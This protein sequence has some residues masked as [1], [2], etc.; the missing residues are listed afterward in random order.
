ML[1]AGTTLDER[2][3]LE[4]LL[5]RGGQASVWRARDRVSGE[6]RALKILS[7]HGAHPT[8]L[9]RARREARSLVAV[10]HPSVVRCYGL[11][12]DP[13]RELLAL[14][15]EYVVGTTLSAALERGQLSA[16]AREHAALHLARALAHRHARGIVHRDLKPSNVMLGEGFTEAPEAGEHIKLLDFGIATA[17]GNPEPMTRL[18]VEVGTRLFMAPE[19]LMPSWFPEGSGDLPASDV[20]S[21]GVVAHQLLTGRHPLRS[22]W[23]ERDEEL[24]LAYRHRAPVELTSSSAE[25]RAVLERALTFTPEQRP[26][27]AAELL[28]TLEPSHGVTTLAALPLA[29]ATRAHAGLLRAE[30]VT[31][32]TLPGA[33]EGYPG[34]PSLTQPSARAPALLGPPYSSLPPSPH[35]EIPPAPPRSGARPRS[36]ALALGLGLAALVASLVVVLVGW[37]GWAAWRAAAQ[38][39]D[40]LELPSSAPNPSLTLEL[41]PPEP[42]PAPSPWRHYVCDC[43]GPVKPES[44]RDLPRDLPPGERW[45]F[46]PSWV[47]RADEPTKNVLTQ[48]PDATLCAATRAGATRCWRLA[49]ERDRAPLRVTTEDVTTQSLTITVLSASAPGA[50][51]LGRTTLPVD[52][53]RTS[54]LL[55]GRKFGGFGDAAVKYGAFWLDP[56]GDSLAA[57]R[58]RAR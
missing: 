33:T 25:W 8:S 52:G 4:L 11:F 27:S 22:P 10:E 18:G 49:D 6:L 57:C 50:R 39:A 48:H 7:L 14:V 29:P 15:L 47:S 46:T 5:G 31:A 19:R 20:F 38:P 42:A 30:A 40:Q 1:E 45:D 13:R 23:P 43:S 58:Q 51:L 44:C 53:L 37:R 16:A 34:P 17:S 55:H 21:W 41:P 2:Y 56:P 35:V 54:V 24:A 36:P 32:A 26:R 3:V 12:E 9:E 28:S